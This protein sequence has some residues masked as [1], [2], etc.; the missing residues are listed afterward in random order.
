MSQLRDKGFAPLLLPSPAVRPLQMYLRRGDD[1]RLYH[2]LTTTDSATAFPAVQDSFSAG[3]LAGV[4]EVTEDLDFGL[5]LVSNAVSFLTGGTVNIGL[6][7]Q[8][9]KKISYRYT[10]LDRQVVEFLPARRFVE[11]LPLQEYKEISEHKTYIVLE[12]LRA[13]GIQVA[14]LDAHGQKLSAG[15]T[16][17]LGLAVE[18]FHS[19]DSTLTFQGDTPVTIGYRA[20]FINASD[21]LEMNDL[22]EVNELP[23]L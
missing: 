13:K 22:T 17:V 8:G 5:S 21:R 9:A 16:E 1:M 20:V 15:S 4:S 11:S 7:N 19:D 10:N 2:T 6:K 12:T 23:D 14:V 18:S 3:A